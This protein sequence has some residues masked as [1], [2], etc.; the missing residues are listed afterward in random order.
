MFPFDPAM[1]ACSSS[2]FLRRWN[3]ASRSSIDVDARF[4]AAA[5]H[6]NTKL[7]TEDKKLRDAAPNLTQSLADAL[8]G[9]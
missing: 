9:S 7:V 4:L 6:L 1:R 2:L 8:A 3:C 5:M